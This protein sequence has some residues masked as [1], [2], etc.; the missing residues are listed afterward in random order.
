MLGR[1]PRPSGE[2]LEAAVTAGLAAVGVD[3]VQLGVLP[4]PGV[5]CLTRLREADF[6]VVISASHN[7]MPDNGIKF[8][9]AGGAKL[10]EVLESRIEKLL[11]SPVELPIGAGVGRVRTDPGAAEEYLQ[12]A[13]ATL[14]TDLSG[15][16]VV[17]DCANGAAVATAPEALRRAG[18]H[19]EAIGIATDGEHINDGCGSTH[20]ELL[21]RRVVETGADVG[22]AHDGDADRCLAVDAT[23]AVVDGDA[24]LAVLGLALHEQG[25]L[26]GDTVVAT[27]MSNL[28]LGR[29]L[30]RA[31]IA[32]ARTDV[33]DRYVLEALQRDGHV[34]GGEQSGHV[35]LLD[36]ATTG[37][38]MLT[39]LHL[40]ARMAATGRSLA[41]LASV[42]TRYPQV[43]LNVRGV[44][45]TRVG[46]DPGV[47]AALTAAEAALGGDGRVVLRP[48]GTEPL[49]RVMVEAA[50]TQIAS[51]VA[52][53][54][55]AAV[56]DRLATTR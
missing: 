16:R 48:S 51:E 43:L 24:I 27:V 6:A 55:A 56:R 22:I 1:D 19:V 12:A 34:L 33:G 9:G 36:H 49:V 42:F 17:V 14:G 5:A 20:L 4:T 37:D 31:G 3:V 39:A 26:A 52:E 28:G 38:G 25:R 46:T 53:G 50:T 23:G 30:E 47:A 41:D 11:G 45:R 18:A 29:A 21:Q 2:F 40:L 10:T 8:F 15:L 54:V 35:I 44:D 32:L 7:P 13:L